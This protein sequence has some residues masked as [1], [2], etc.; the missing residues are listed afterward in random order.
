MN[1]ELKQSMDDHLNELRN[2]LLIMIAAIL[3]GITVAFYYAIEVIEAFK[4]MAHG[5]QL[6]FVQLT[7]GEVLLC[8]AKLSAYLGIAAAS[9]VILYQL[10]R[11]VLPALVQR[12]RD[13]LFWI[14]GGGGL[15][16]LCGVVFAY[17]LVIP[18]A[19]TYLLDFGQ[20]VAKSQ[21]SIALYVD[22]CSSLLILTGI[23]FELPL[24]LFFLSLTGLITSDKLLSQWRM[25]IVI[26]AIGAAIITPSQDPFTMTI[27]ITAMIGLYFLSI[28]PIRLIGR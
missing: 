4:Q 20:N 10:M 3:T 28:L 26:I 2:R 18:S 16:F 6:E 17:F 15:L 11:F 27:V 24:V 22:F 25:A 13:S 1:D 8:S 23:L 12:E 14:I 7:P 5:V 21:I 19:L 9:P